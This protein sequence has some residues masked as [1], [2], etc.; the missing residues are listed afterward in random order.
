MAMLSCT[1]PDSDTPDWPWQDPEEEVVP[2]EDPQ[3]SVDPALAKWTDVS[4]EF[5]TLPAHIKVYKSPE[6]L[7]GKAAIAYLAVAD[8]KSAKWDIWSV[9]SDDTYVTADSYRRPSD[10]YKEGSWPIVINGGYFFIS[11]GKNYTSSLAVRNSELLA[12]NINYASETWKVN[13]IYY[14][15]RAAFLELENGNFDACW[16]YKAGTGHYMYTAPA[17]NSWSKSPLAPPTSSS[18]EGA[19]TFAAKTGIGGGPVLVNNGK[20]TDTYVAELFN[21]TSG[22]GP[23][24]NQPRTA[25]GVTADKRMMFFVCEGRQMT[26]G[27][28]GL[29]T[30]DVARVL[31]DLGCVEAINL[32]GGGSSCMLV[33]GKETIKVSDGS[34]RYVASTLMLK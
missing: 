33:N 17:D 25:V 26:S 24:S 7:Q 3:P 32:D 10:V 20:F 2:E 31:I 19:A 9:K 6:T 14:P 11:E 23:D 27:V 29:T 22:I 8:M 5:G 28:Q 30:A 18:P 13:E 21:G 16:T 34:Q 4:S 15:T 12:Y 1:K